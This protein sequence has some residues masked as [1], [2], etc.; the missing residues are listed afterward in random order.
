MKSIAALTKKKS[1]AQKEVNNRSFPVVAIG[2][3]AGGLEAITELLKNLPP[4]TGMSFIFVQHLS[5]DHKSMLT[6]ILSKATKMHVQEAANKLLIKPDN[7]Y[8]IPPDKEMILVDGY[9]KLTPRRKDPVVHLP[10]DTFFCSLAEKH[11]ESAIGIILSGSASDGTRGLSAIKAAGGVTFAQDDSAKFNSM[12]QSAI[13]A[14]AVDFVLSPK[15]IAHE[16]ARLSKH[17]YV[18]RHVPAAGNEDEIDNSDPDLKL[19]LHLLH[20]ETGVDFSYYKMATI[21][22]RILRRMYLY[23]IE[24][25]KAYAKLMTEKSD[26]INILYQDLLINV[27]SFFR[28][29]EAHHYLKATLLP[30]LLKSKEADETLRIWIPACSTGEEAYSM[31]MTILE[32]QT[33]NNTNIPVR[34]FATDLSAQAIAKARVGEYPGEQLQS[35]SPK[36]LQQFYTKSSGSN[37]RI[38]KVVRDMCVFAHHN[39][40]SHPPFSRVDFISCCNLLIYLDKAAQKKALSTFHYALNDG[41]YLMLGKSETTGTCGHLFTQEHNK[42]KI[43][44]RKKS[45]GARQLPDLLPR[46]QPHPAEQP[47]ASQPEQNRSSK[48]P[49]NTIVRAN[50]PGSAIDSI[51]LSAFRWLL[52]TVLFFPLPPFPIPDFVFFLRNYLFRAFPFLYVAA[53]HVR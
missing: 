39:I 50:V 45:P 27:T 38:A 35:V 21:K 17:D 23:K 26:E 29:T 53:V 37:Y 12:P 52:P 36:H 48:L 20:K 28:D 15:Q 43:Y 25:L 40:L 2:A 51:L 33:G 22:R 42:Y 34:I 8:V 49:K 7:F 31:A 1:P 46:Y 32:I 3:S 13:A 11:K 14:G 16:L 44:S 18:K 24:S 4:N 30:R 10:I 6:S 47:A 5:P 9:I 19:I 41:G